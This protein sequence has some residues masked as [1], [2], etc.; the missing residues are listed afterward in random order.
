MAML[1]PWPGREQRQAA[2]S[3]ARDQKE[4]SRSGAAHAAEIE[5]DIMQMAERNHFSLL[6]AEEI[7][8]QHRRRGS[9]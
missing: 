2:I 7:K 5:R 3:H 8:R 6:I 4:R 1:F 9:S